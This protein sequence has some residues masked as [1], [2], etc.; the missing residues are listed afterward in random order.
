MY[1]LASSIYIRSDHSKSLLNLRR[2]D[3]YRN[4]PVAYLSKGPILGVTPPHGRTKHNYFFFK[5]YHIRSQKWMVVVF[6]NGG[7]GVLKEFFHDHHAKIK[8][9]HLKHKSPMVSLVFE[10]E[11]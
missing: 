7:R 5:D 8:I 3:N 11:Q 2:M 9:T 4:R 1:R 10:I 6:A